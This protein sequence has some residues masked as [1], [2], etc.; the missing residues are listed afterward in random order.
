M[1]F[2]KE[3]LVHGNRACNYSGIVAMTFTMYDWI[4]TAEEEVTQIWKRPWSNLKS[5]YVFIRLLSVGAQIIPVIISLQPSSADPSAPVITREC[6]WINGF[7]GISSQLLTMAVQAILLLRVEA[8]YQ[9][10][11]R[12]QFLLRALYIGEFISI[13]VMLS[14][15]LPELQYELHCLVTYFPPEFAIPS[16]LLPVI[17][18]FIL[19]I[20]TMVKFYAAIRDGWARQPLIFRFLQDGIWAFGLPLV[21]MT[22][23][24][25]CIAALPGPFSS[26]AYSWILAIPGF[27]GCRLILNMSHLLKRHSEGPSTYPEQEF[28]LD[29]ELP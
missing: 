16:L 6:L 28:Q 29:T 20:L 13:T 12:L 2:S 18:E 3:L 7:Q 14:I 1:H 5:L 4:S 25:V 27:A 22:I 10:Q 15:A 8:L 11:K 21:I 26:I 23:N 17:V 19:F 24:T 9:R